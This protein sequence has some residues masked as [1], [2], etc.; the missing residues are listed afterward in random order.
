MIRPKDIP[1]CTGRGGWTDAVELKDGYSVRVHVDYDQDMGAPWEEHDGHGPVSEWT[2]RDK[3]PGERV[4]A[5]DRNHRRYYDFAEACKIAR[6]DG[7]GFK[8]MY[9][10]PDLSDN[11][12]YATAEDVKTANN[13][14]FTVDQLRADRAKDDGYKHGRYRLTDEARKMTPKARA[15]KAADEDFENLRR[16]CDNE[17]HWIVVGVE[18]SR[19]GEVLETDYCGGIE[20]YTDYW[21]EHAAD[22]ANSTIKADQR[23]RRQV[24][25]AAR[26]E[27]RERRYWAARDVITK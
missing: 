16:W 3:L 15:A 8:N 5:T 4:L 24:A 2:T 25:A 11:G 21:R 12:P 7:W 23:E 6:R 18:V 17:W 9:A 26:R 22:V 13:L 20:D 27:T 10:Y 1:S 14:N 19:N